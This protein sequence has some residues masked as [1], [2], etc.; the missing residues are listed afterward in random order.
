MKEKHSDKVLAEMTGSIRAY[1]FIL[2]VEQR[3]RVRLVRKIIRLC[4]E[5]A[6]LGGSQYKRVLKE[7]GL[8][9]NEY[10]KQMD[11]LAKSCSKFA[12][13]NQEEELDKVMLRWTQLRLKAEERNEIE[14]TVLY[15]MAMLG[16]H[17]SRF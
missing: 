7:F 8:P 11:L 17:T 3:Q 10:Q 1:E 6:R 4:E 9:R 14:G 16:L 2:K 13:A 12:R 5:N 15:Q